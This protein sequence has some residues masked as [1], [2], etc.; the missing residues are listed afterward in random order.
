M[1]STLTQPVSCR[2]EPL[3]ADALRVN[4]ELRGQTLSSAIADLIRTAATQ[5]TVSASR[6]SLR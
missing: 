1:P 3:Y 6:A 4:A 2:V 5:T